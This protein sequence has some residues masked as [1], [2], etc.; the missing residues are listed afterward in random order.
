[1]PIGPNHTGVW[2]VPNTSPPTTVVNGLRR[3]RSQAGE[4]NYTI[5]GQTQDNA[6]AAL[7]SCTVRLF[8]TATNVMEQTTTSDATG[9]YTFVVD[10]TQ[11]WYVIASNGTPVQ[12]VTGNTLAGA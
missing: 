1:M 2:G 10:K 8:N 6:G 12:G 7:A 3:T 4:R 11:T 5:T 9:A